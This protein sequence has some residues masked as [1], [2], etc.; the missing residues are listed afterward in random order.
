MRIKSLIAASLLHLCVLISGLFNFN[1]AKKI[2]ATESIVTTF[3]VAPPHLP[4]YAQKRLLKRVQG[5]N[6][7]SPAMVTMK[8]SPMQRQHI[9]NLRPTNLK[10]NSTRGL[11]N[12]LHEKIAE[13]QIYPARAVFLN[14][15]GSVWIHLWLYPNG[16]IDNIQLQHSSGFFELDQAAL[17]AVRAVG[18]IND[19]ADYIK[20][21]HNFI[22]AVKFNL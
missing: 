7:T 21:P 11:L 3:V 18:R 16:N 1:P 2:I 4:S 17:A 8:A 20:M 5:L 9:N 22:V 13:Q 15:E 12:L 14:H 19:A 6:K 10:F